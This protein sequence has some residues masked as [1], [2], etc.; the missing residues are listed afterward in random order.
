[1][2]HDSPWKE[3]VEEL[4]E[5]FL[6]FFFPQVHR[7]IDFSK[8]YQFL[9]DEL[10]KIIRGSKT[11]KRYADQLIRVYLHDGAEQWLLIHIEIQGYKQQTFPERMYIYNYRI[12]DKFRKDVVSLA[13]VTD[14]SPEFRPD[15]YRRSLLGCE[16]IFRY[17]MVKI[18]DY[19]DHWAELEANPNPFAM[20]VRAYL[21]TLETEGNTQERYTWKKKF[22]LEL[23]RSGMERETILAVYKFIDWIMKLPEE[24]DTELNEEISKSEETTTMPY[25]TTAERIGIKK[26]MTQGIAAI[27]EN[28][29]GASS[30]PLIERAYKMRD[31]IK[32][33]DAFQ[34]LIV[35]ITHAQ[36][37]GE[38]EEF[39]A[40][41]ELQYH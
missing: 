22:L 13:L 36:S 20:V 33:P 2:E 28:K 16:V 34:K 17:P 1:M 15:E 11:G 10:R 5:Y 24:L 4:F 38:A 26:G 35:K 32:D 21:K 9:K 39:F 6:A 30:E 29:F 3:V 19:R 31:Q 25:I 41:I 23:Y 27:L 8:G 40:E 37:L 14:D 7:A 12:F 18:L